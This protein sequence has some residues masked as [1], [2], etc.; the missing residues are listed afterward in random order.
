MQ[1]YSKLNKTGAKVRKKVDSS[2]F[3]CTFADRCQ[4]R[5]LAT[6]PDI[7]DF[8]QLQKYTN[9]T[10]SMKKYALSAL[11]FF[12]IIT[13]AQTKNPK[14]EEYILKYS[15]LA[16][17]CQKEH[18][19][20]A[21]ITMAQGILESAAGE[22]KLAKECNNHFGIK[23][24]NS[25]YGK[26]MRK[27]DDAI[28]ECFRCYRTVKDSYEDHADFLKKQRYSFLYDYPVTDYKSWAHGLKR[29]GYATDPKYPQKLIQIIEDY[30]LYDLGSDAKSQ[31]K[32]N[33]QSLK[34]E[35]NNQLFGYDETKNNGVKCY[36][37]RSDDT[38]KN[39]SKETGITVAELLY[40]NDLPQAI[41]LFRDDYIY[42]APKK[43]HTKKDVPTYTVRAGDSMHSIS[44]EYGIKLK[45]L[46]KLNGIKYGTPAK[47]GQKLKLHK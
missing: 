44:Q 3:I 22:S 43:N 6:K 7:K 12:S 4:E 8:I 27:N 17:E 42:L 46:Y 15:D 36:K 28:G 23:C 24:G 11:M 10:G 29:A 38:F 31:H 1:E 21:S 45:S 16:V 5:I 26:S 37:L 13:N 40:F 14:Y 32:Q 47:V 2:I 30:Q 33:I 35:D 34:P 39:I 19:I 25:W 9:T 41:P 18:G 20:P